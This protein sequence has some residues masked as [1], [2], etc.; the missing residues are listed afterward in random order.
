MNPLWSFK[1]FVAATGGNIQ[2][3]APDIG[4][5]SIDTRTLCP[6]DAYFAITGDVHDGHDFIPQAFAAGASV[7]VVAKDYQGEG[8]LLRVD[9]PLGALGALAVAARA[10]SHAGIIAVTGSVGKTGSKEALKLAL[11]PGGAVHVSEKSYNNQW[12]VPLSLARMPAGAKY[13]VFEIGMNHPGEITPLV[14]LVRPHAVL[15]TTVEAV[16][17]GFFKS[18]EAIAAAKAEIFD[19]LEPGGSAVLNRDNVH[20]AFLEERAMAGG[21]GKIIGFGEAQGAKA[22]VESFELYENGSYVKATICGH[23]ISY[24]IGAPGRHMVINSLGVLAGV[25]ALGGDVSAAALALADLRPPQ[26]RGAR[27]P[28]AV[29]GERATLIDESYNANP[30][31]MRAA[32]SVLGAANCT[33]GGRRIAVLGDMLELG[34]FAGQL[35]EELAQQVAG[36]KVDMVFSCGE[37]MAVF[38]DKIPQAIRGAYSRTARGLQDQLVDEIRGGDVVM[39]KGSLGSK[40]GPLAEA[41]EKRYPKA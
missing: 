32:L 24:K 1:D 23:Q 5:I 35:H 31:S 17:I 22:R 15:I 28:L 9:D 16:H 26:G 30:A 21:A 29:N 2:G 38:W 6:G 7:A 4:G 33:R 37:Q 18:I 20:F 8:A 27:V 14:K 12:G 13:G 39:I 19:G 10:R 3:D 25:A 11:A 41:L 40:M 34:E 36:T